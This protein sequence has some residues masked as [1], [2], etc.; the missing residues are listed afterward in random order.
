MLFINNLYHKL[1]K[2]KMIL[3]LYIQYKK[4]NPLDKGSA[5]FSLI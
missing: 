5:S 2:A 4:P 3:P 1:T